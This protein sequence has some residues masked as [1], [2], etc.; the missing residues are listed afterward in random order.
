MKYDGILEYFDSYALDVDQELNFISNVMKRML[1]E[2]TKQLTK[3]IDN[4]EYKCIY[5]H[6]KLQSHLNFDDTCG[7]WVTSRILNFKKG[8]NLKQY[9]NYLNFMVEQNDLKGNL[10][11][12]LV[13]IKE[14]NYLPR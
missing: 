14:V 12:D 3:L 13:L 6:T 10:K 9:I 1:G 8:M 11:F 7:R 5:N 4:S 2:N